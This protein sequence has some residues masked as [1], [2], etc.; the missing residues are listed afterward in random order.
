MTQE[1]VQKKIT[2]ELGSVGLIRYGNRGLV[3]E[4]PLTELTGDRGRKAFQEMSL[5]DDT[6]GGMLFAI[7]TRIRKVA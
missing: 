6:V 5:N 7:E 2:E 4:E 3:Y 1:P